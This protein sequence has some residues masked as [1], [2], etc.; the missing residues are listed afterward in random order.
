[1]GAVFVSRLGLVLRERQLNVRELQRRLHARGHPISRG[2]IDRLVSDRP[3][4]KVELDVLVPLLDE[5]G[6]S[7]DDAFVRMPSE[8]LV[9]RNAA[10]PATAEAARRL[11]SNIRRARLADA[12]GELDQVAARLEDDLRTTHPELFDGRGRL[13]QRALSRLLLEQFGG[14][15]AINGDDVLALIHGHEPTAPTGA[16]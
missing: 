12:D 10:R 11:A 2:A 4:R 9:N 8:T 7:F 6:V 13:R 15:Q 16:T 5:L 14:K 1:M 3:V